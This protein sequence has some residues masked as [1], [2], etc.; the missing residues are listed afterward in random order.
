MTVE[1]LGDNS[2]IGARAVLEAFDRGF[3]RTRINQGEIDQLVLIVVNAR[4]KSE[5]RLSTRQKPPGFFT[6]AA[7]TATVAMDNYSHE[8]VASLREALYA[9]VQPQ[10][11]ER[12]CIDLLAE[13]CPDAPRPVAFA[14]EV[15]PFVIE[16]NFE[17]AALLPGEDPRYYLD[18]PT[19]FALSAEQVEKLVNIGPRLLLASPQFQCLLKVLE[20]ES[21]GLP[22]PGEC[23]KGA[24]IFP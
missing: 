13:H 4:T 1:P 20:A 23:P 18:L 10:R 11:D 5:D 16:I 9:R 17:A 19:S 21:R 12:A 7:K 2:N 22:R 6:V 3:I 14:A 15:D 24:G 8:S